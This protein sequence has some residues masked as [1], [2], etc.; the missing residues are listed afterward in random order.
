MSRFRKGWMSLNL[1]KEYP[2]CFETLVFATLW[3]L[4]IACNTPKTKENLKS[5]HMTPLISMT[6]TGLAIRVL[7]FP[8]ISRFYTPEKNWPLKQ[9]LKQILIKNPFWLLQNS[10]QFL[11]NV[12]V[13]SLDPQMKSVAH[14]LSECV[15]SDP[16]VVFASA[17]A[18]RSF[19]HV[20]SE[21]VGLV[22]GQLLWGHQGVAIQLL[23]K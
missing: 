4:W 7:T 15:W 20:C 17:W 19:G 2:F 10:S 23:S 9:R 6:S 8:D 3:I 11:F 14:N 1:Y 5:H 21:C 13:D 22:A 12:S 16:C 18:L